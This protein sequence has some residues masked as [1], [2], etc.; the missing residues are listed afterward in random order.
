MDFQVSEQTIRDLAYYIVAAGIV[1]SVLYA[2]VKFGGR[3][4][5]EQVATI[6]VTPGLLVLAVMS[7]EV[8]FAF[9]GISLFQGNGG[10]LYACAV[11]L[12]LWRAEQA[13]NQASGAISGWIVRR[14]PG[15]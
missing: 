15:K 10:I 7:I 1:V 2:I 9:V 6:I 3:P 8:A 13:H 14:V 4:V 5:L 11:A 12:G